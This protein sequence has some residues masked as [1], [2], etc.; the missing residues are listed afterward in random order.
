LGNITVS[1]L[2]ELNKI[3][4]LAI[5]QNIQKIGE[6]IK[7][8]LR[9]FVQ[10]NWYNRSYEPQQYERTF[11]LIDSLTVSPVKINGNEYSVQIYYDTDKILPMDGTSDKPWTRHKSIVT[12]TPSGVYLPLWIEE[13]QDS[14]IFSFEG[15][16]PVQDTIDWVEEDKYL[17]NR[18]KELL[19]KKGFK[20]I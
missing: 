13:G 11:Q 1:S 10:E 6:E 8:V 12:Q 14:S 7:G 2:S 19:E 18:M 20:C 4:E 5:I 15:V 9:H 3:I 17:L 16:H